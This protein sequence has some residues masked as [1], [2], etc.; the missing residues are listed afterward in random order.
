MQDATLRIH[1][2]RRIVEIAHG[3]IP[4]RSKQDLLSGNDPQE[5]IVVVVS[6]GCQFVDPIDPERSMISDEIGN[7][8]S[9]LGQK[10]NGKLRRRCCCCFVEVAGFI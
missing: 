2:R 4:D 1:S 7:K 10:D 8:L 6:M 3:R 9:V 5:I